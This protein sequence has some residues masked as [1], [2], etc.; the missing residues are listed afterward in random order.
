MKT[1]TIVGVALILVCSSLLLV[2]P[3]RA[4]TR[5]GRVVVNVADSKSYHMVKE[6][7]RAYPTL[8]DGDYDVSCML[9]RGAMYYY[10]EITV[11][12]KTSQPLQ[13]PMDFA[14]LSFLRGALTPHRVNTIPVARAL[15]DTSGEEF[16]PSLPPYI[17]PVY[18]TTI[19]STTT[20]RGNQ[21]STT[22]EESTTADYSGQVVADVWTGVSNVVGA[23]SFYKHQDANAQLSR[24]LQAHIQTIYDMPLPPG[25]SRTIVAAFW[26][27]KKKKPFN[28]AITLPGDTFRF[29]YKE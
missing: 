8:S 6:G 24:F 29:S 23:H 28:L 27:V 14:S 13:I 22:E 4:E 18:E 15:A 17:P 12:N 7:T 5:F 20:M 21:T 16:V 11:N 19:Y 3:G 2:A 1:L 10:A 26:G 25:Q 9:Y